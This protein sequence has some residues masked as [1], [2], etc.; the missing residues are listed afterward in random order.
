ML[1]APAPWRHIA[2]D[3]PTH[4]TTAPGKLT[5]VRAFVALSGIS[6]RFRESVDIDKAVHPHLRGVVAGAKLTARRR[7]PTGAY[8]S[9]SLAF[10]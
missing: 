7:S 8:A 1:G 3:A 4:Q 5:R 9:F 6:R 2:L 10:H